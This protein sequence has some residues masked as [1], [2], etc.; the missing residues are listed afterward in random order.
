MFQMNSNHTV[1]ELSFYSK[2][3]MAIV[4]VAN[5][6]WEDQAEFLESQGLRPVF[7][8]PALWKKNL[9]GNHLHLVLQYSD[10]FLS[11]CTDPVWHLQF[12]KALAERFSIEWQP[13]ADWYLQARIT[14]D[15][16]GNIYLDQQRYAKAI[17]KRY[18]PNAN[19][20][21]SEEDKLKYINPLPSDIIFSSNDRSPDTKTVK[22]LETNY[23]FKSI[24]TIASLN[25]L[26][27][28]AFEELFAIGK[29]CSFMQLPGEIHF[30]ALLHLLHNIRCHPPNAL[31]FYQ[32]PH[33]SPLASLLKEAEVPQL[34]PTF[35]TITDSAW[36]ACDDRKSTGC[37][38]IFFQGGLVD[39]SSLVPTPI[40]M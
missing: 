31:C 32:D 1:A 27:N 17:I 19:L 13:R 14:S 38:M 36:G 4:T 11:G 20:V 37:N 6:L 12:Q 18:L 35:L 33:K 3:S 5:F 34:D 9:P 15:S 23:G 28:T 26:A 39:F 2:L 21:P 8:M 16:Q 7:G 24:E 29:L 30:K 25:F 40:T 10:D 22:Q